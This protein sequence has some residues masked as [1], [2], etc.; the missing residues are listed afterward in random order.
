VSATKLDCPANAPANLRASSIK[1]ERSE[2]PQIARRVQRSLYRLDI[3]ARPKTAGHRRDASVAIR[4]KK[5][6]QRRCRFGAPDVDGVVRWRVVIVG[7]EVHVDRR[8]DVNAPILRS[9]A[10]IDQECCNALE[11]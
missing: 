7:A 11:F 6:E 1:C 2:L 4:G 3:A 9:F 10:W 5:L 8:Q